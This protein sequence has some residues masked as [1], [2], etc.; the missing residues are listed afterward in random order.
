M[1]QSHLLLFNNNVT[2]F[3]LLIYFFASV[4]S[5]LANTNKFLFNIGTA[6]SRVYL[7]KENYVFV[8]NNGITFAIFRGKIEKNMKVQ[9]ERKNN[10]L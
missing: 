7:T 1:V 10:I 8:E 9:N 4:E 3:F 6:D 5:N 2:V